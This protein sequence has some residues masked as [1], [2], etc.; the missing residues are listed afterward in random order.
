[1]SDWVSPWIK[2]FWESMEEKLYFWERTRDVSKIPFNMPLAISVLH[3]CHAS[4]NATD[5]RVSV[6]FTLSRDPYRNL[7][8]RHS[9][10]IVLT[11]LAYP[12]YRHFQ[13]TNP[14]NSHFLLSRPSK[15][16]GIP[17]LSAME[18]PLWSTAANTR[19]G[20]PTSIEPLRTPTTRLQDPTLTA[21]TLT[22][23][24]QYCILTALPQSTN[25]NIL[26]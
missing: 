13:L 20:K 4:R 1:M 25:S 11:N 26:Q 7:Q 6:L 8:C 19:Q 3:T 12:D 22:T 14:P 16:M 17:N 10:A 23:T 18:H 9:P 21:L 24:K 2:L 5:E 15:R